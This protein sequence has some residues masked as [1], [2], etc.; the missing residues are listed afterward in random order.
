MWCG[1]RPARSS[2]R[3]IGVPADTGLS[4]VIADTG[5]LMSPQ[6]VIVDC[7]SDLG[8]LTVEST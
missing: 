1:P 2:P 7:P 6:V 3:V 5:P 8:M 4:G